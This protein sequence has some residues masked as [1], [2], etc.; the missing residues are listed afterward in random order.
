MR[1]QLSTELEVRGVQRPEDGAG[2]AATGV[3]GLLQLITTI[4]TYFSKGA[5]R[6]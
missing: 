5:P 1:F 6:K 4:P 3:C 2:T